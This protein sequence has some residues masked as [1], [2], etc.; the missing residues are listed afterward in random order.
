MVVEENNSVILEE[1]ITAEKDSYQQKKFI[2]KH[3]RW[4]FAIAAVGQGA[5][6]A[7]MSSW[8]GRF[9]TDVVGIDLLVV[10]IILWS[11]RFVDAVFNPIMGTIVDRTRTKYGK[12]R[13]Y[14]F[15]TPILI[16]ILTILL[17]TNFNLS[18]T[19]KIIYSAAI[20]IVWELVYT[21]VDVPF[22][23]MPVAMTP[24]EKERSSFMSFSRLLNSIGGALPVVLVS[25][26]MADNIWGLS[27]GI[28]Y[29]AIIFSAIAIIPFTMT[30]FTTKERIVPQKE[31][32]NFK[33]SMKL[34]K[35]NKPLLLIL[36]FGILCFG[37]YMIQAGYSYAADYVFTFPSTDSFF[38]KQRQLI[39]AALIGIGMFPAML[40]T[41]KL[42]RKFEYKNLVIGAGL[43][44]GAVLILFFIVEILT[45]FSF[46]VALPFLFVGGMPLGVFNIITASLVADSIDYLE[47]K[48][49]V[50]TEGLGMSCNSFA[51]RMGAALAAG[52]IPLILKLF[53]YIQPITGENGNAIMQE[54]SNKTKIAIL[55]VISLVPAISFLLSTIPMFFYKYTGKVK[56][57][58]LRDLDKSRQISEN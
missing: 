31:K 47:W 10:T 22:W 30:F 53:D 50:R 41:P 57:E 58:C 33:Q 49:G 55:A 43:I 37:R 5:I 45:N 14:L 16:C 38:Y 12:M 20:L 6:Y 29:S 3:E 1:E 4:G 28:S 48:E 19:G 25:V 56:Q 39:G 24:N 27:K 11:A 9:F 7:M 44:S 13:P 32:Q 26:V 23:G 40:I 2:P 46:F 17:F 51:Q 8:V 21:T 35:K 52:G 54:Q 42:M 15:G 36:L 18:P 34:L